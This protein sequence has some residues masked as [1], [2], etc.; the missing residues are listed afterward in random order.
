MDARRARAGEHGPEQALIFSI[1]EVLD[2]RLPADAVI[3]SDAGDFFIA[4][5]VA[6][7]VGGDRRYLGPTSG[8][9]GYGIPAAVAAK[10]AAPD[11]TSVALCG[12][13]G[14]MMT[15]QEL[16]TAFRCSA[17]IIVIVFNNDCFGS[18]RRHQ[19][20]KYGGRRSGV[21]LT[22]P[23]FAAMGRLFGL[24]G[25]VATTDEEFRAALDKALSRP[26]RGH[27]VEVRL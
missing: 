10:L 26:E 18:I 8:S 21:A 13:G 27:V 2:R 23:D 24:D 19:D 17:P 15:I 25:S 11:R 9:M 1:A 6:F 22:N 3:T 5:G 16:E 7:A 4:A 12:D 20:A 14:A